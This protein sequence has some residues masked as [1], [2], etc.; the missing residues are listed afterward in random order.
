MGKNL[1]KRGLAFLMAGTIAAGLLS[2][3]G[4]SKPRRRI[5]GTSLTVT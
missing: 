4:G 3:G 1:F 2:G 5:P